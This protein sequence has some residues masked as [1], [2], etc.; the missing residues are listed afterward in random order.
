MWQRRGYI[1]IL[2]CNLILLCGCSNTKT[3]NKK[4]VSLKPLD[5]FITPNY[6]A[7]YYDNMQFNAYY[8]KEESMKHLPDQGVYGSGNAFILRYDGI[9]YMYLG[10]SNYL[11]TGV[12]AYQSKDLM[13]WEPVDNGVNPKGKVADDNR[14][15]FTYPPCVSQYNNKFYL[16]VYVKNTLITQGNYILESDS[17][18]GPFTFVSH[19]ED[20]SPDCYTIAATTLDID[21]DIFIDDNE[22]VYFMSARG[23]SYFTGIRAFK[24]P[25]MDLV[26]YDENSYINI[27]QSNVGGW[28]EGNGIFKRNGMYYLMYTGSN[29][30]SPGYLTHY[31]VALD[32]SWKNNFGKDSK[33]QAPGFTQGIDF[34]MGCETEDTFYS[35]GHA[36]SLLGPDMDSLYYHY[37]SVN[38]SGPNCTFAID[39]LI[40]NG[41]SMDTSQSQYHA[42]TPKMPTL[43]SYD[44]MN[45]SSFIKDNNSLLTKSEFNGTLSMEFN[46]VGEDVKCVFDYLDQNNYKYVYVDIQNKK[47]L[48]NEVANGKEKTLSVGLIVRD[49][50]AVDLHKTIRIAIKDSK[51]DVYFDNLLKIKDIEINRTN[52][53]IGY[54]Y[55]SKFIPSYTAISNVA[56]GLSDKLEPKQSFINI[57]AESYLPTGIYEGCGSSFSGNSGFKTIEKSEF[58][59]KYIGIGK[60][61]LSNPGD[62]ATY[63][64]DF[65]DE[66]EYKALYMTLNKNMGS[67]KIGVRVD[68]SEVYVLEIPE[69]KP[70]NNESLIK[71]YVGRI[72]VSKGIH[73]ISFICLDDEFEFI[74]FTFN[75]DSSST[76]SYNETLETVPS[77]GMNQKTLWRFEALEGD[78]K[79]SL[80]CKEGNRSLVFF[81]DS[82]LNNYTVE[83]DFR[84]NGDS[85]SNS[86]FIIE[87]ARY[88]NSPYVTEDYKYIQGYYISFSK[89][90]VKIEKINY[91]HTDS[92]A[93]AA[94]LTL[95]PGEWNHL[96]ITKDGNTIKVEVV[97]SQNQAKTLE[98]V[99]DMIFVGGR[100]GFYSSGASMSYKNL[101]IEG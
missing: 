56:K 42:V 74:S 38:S 6:A 98:F 91:T 80:T 34:P 8:N 48:L 11:G 30:L 88:S 82:S 84:L 49:Y 92:N 58:N 1:I 25:S 32:D 63:I 54:L 68:G 94:R 28:T 50:D 62:N 71:T 67:K 65:N 86:G 20:L 39:R 33:I 57:G 64:V 101:K 52:G 10:S 31:S 37:F 43:F 93:D 27:D 36:T 55:N 17:P 72:P 19:N 18:I 99:D 41:A 44:P 75:K 2:I 87:G 79:K 46:Y 78:D 22:D 24:M 90:M 23:D 69:V 76:F 70:T 60:M 100:F 96:K 4:A 85:V 5:N 26:S 81:G 3:N 95:N 15:Y 89:R 73:Q 16:Y 13:H 12:Y 14:L 77:S 59:S 97:T 40:F 83:C 29:I 9:Y 45:D 51:I 66:C 47:I 61:N 53:K 21:C 35:L 7:T